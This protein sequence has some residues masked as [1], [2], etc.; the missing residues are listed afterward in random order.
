MTVILSA[1]L[2]PVAAWPQPPDHAPAHGY[3]AKHS[4]QHKHDMLH[5]SHHHHGH[6][7]DRDRHRHRQDE[8]VQRQLPEGG[9]V[10]IIFD[11]ERGV[12]VGV[13]L[14]NVFFQDG[15]YYR[16]RSGY[17]QV[18]ARGDGAWKV[19]AGIPIPLSIVEASSGRGTQPGPASIRSP[20]PSRRRD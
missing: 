6:K 8:R 11:S 20:E 4:K 16:E 10:E 7:K 9:G 5:R 13:N 17:W 12:Y 18:S 15:R 14:P 19:A 3:R 1:A 2:L